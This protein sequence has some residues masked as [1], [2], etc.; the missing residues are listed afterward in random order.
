MDGFKEINP[1]AVTDNFIKLIGSDW[2]LIT[3]GDHVE[4]NTMT[5]SWGGVGYI[6]PVSSTLPL[7]STTASLQPV[8]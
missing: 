6:T 5:A 3:A 4:C 8:L 1:A 7:P 2:M